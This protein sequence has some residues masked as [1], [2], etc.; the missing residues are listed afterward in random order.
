MKKHLYLVI[1]AICYVLITVMLIKGVEPVKYEVTVGEA[2]PADI[3]ASRTVVDKVTTERQKDEAE[4]SVASQY[5]LDNAVTQRADR[6]LANVFIGIAEERANRISSDNRYV[7]QI[8]ESEF[9]NFRNVLTSLQQEILNKGVTSKQD[10]LNEISE[11][12]KSRLGSEEAANAGVDILK[13]TIAVNKEF[14]QEKTDA[15]I[16]RVRNDVPNVVYKENQ[17][18]V[19]KGEII[20]EAQYAILSDL[21]LISGEGDTKLV[22]ILG[23]VLFVLMCFVMTG[24][25]FAK[26][27][28]RVLSQ[29][30]SKVITAIVAA[31]TVQTLYICIY[32]Q[33]DYYILPVSICAVLIAILL[34]VKFAIFLNAIIAA[35][36]SVAVGANIYYMCAIIIT[37]TIGAYLFSNITM[38]KK[39]VFSSM[40]FCLYN[41]AVIGIVGLLEGIEV[42]GILRHTLFGMLSAFI[43]S[44]FV[45]GTLPFWETVFDIN[46]P[47]RLVELTNPNQP[48]L[49]RL[50]VEAPGTYHH[51]LMVG[52]L[53][54]AA[55]EAV[56]GNDLLARAGAYYHDIGK[57]YN[58]DMFSENQYLINPHDS[59]MP[60]ESVKYITEHVKEGVRLAGQYKLPS[61]IKNMIYSHHGNTKVSYFYEKAK[62]AGLN[63][64]EEDFRY[65]APKPRT[66]EE[67]IVML[68][69]S[70]EASVRSLD[71]K[72][73]D[74][75]CK[76]ISKVV[77]GKIYDGQL[78]GSDL[79]FWEITEIE[80]AFLK[81]FSG[82]FH[83]RVQYPEQKEKTN[84]NTDNK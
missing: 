7:M 2:S 65:H 6:D 32:S 79:T 72:S 67:A 22:R 26:S 33:V 18:V 43:T 16:Q 41:G 8:S 51:S 23:S 63:I 60:S 39:L 74:E 57:L 15:E 17:I 9:Q 13:N 69:D 11:T 28:N 49:K 20:T 25:Y 35:V 80:N 24:I 48:L 12:L 34:N 71:V 55:C 62:E 83:S 44:V 77:N 19:R 61:A 58:P 40:L 68:S 30:N 47:F 46:T 38:R 56:G 37:G 3:Y 50:L 14:S 70:V 5:E 54:E 36:A 29:N 1:V 75:I 42:M 76:M 31:F 81:V 4:A 78:S 27:R 21:G 82:Y 66:K 84:E 59:L 52:N 64:D 73:E 45:L 10:A 53:A